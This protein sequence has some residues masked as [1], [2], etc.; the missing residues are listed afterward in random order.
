MNFQDMQRRFQSNLHMRS[1]TPEIRHHYNPS[2]P[3]SD[4]MFLRHTPVSN[5][6]PNLAKISTPLYTCQRPQDIHLNRDAA[7]MPKPKALTPPEK[8]YQYLPSLRS[9][10]PDGHTGSYWQ[11]SEQDIKYSMNK[12]PPYPTCIQ[13]SNKFVYPPMR[14]ESPDV[15]QMTEDK[16]TIAMLMNQLQKE[17]REKEMLKV[18]IERQKGYMETLYIENLQAKNLLGQETRE[19]SWLTNQLARTRFELEGLRG[20]HLVT[21]RVAYENG[22]GH[23]RESDVISV[24]HS[25]VTR[26]YNNQMEEMERQLREKDQELCVMRR[27]CED[28]RKQKQSFKEYYENVLH[29]L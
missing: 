19:N 6:R 11:R 29:L 28:E 27:A 4:E 26:G 23:V 22:L 9:N 1:S 20:K 13:E 14:C 12:L 3:T 8:G 17:R 7:F 25:P 21:R 18:K 10:T 15:F 2:S 24:E 5:A 16:K